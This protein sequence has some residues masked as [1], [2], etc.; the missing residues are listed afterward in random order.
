MIDIQDIE[1]RINAGQRSF[2]Y[3]GVKIWNNLS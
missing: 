2:Y 3:R 1:C